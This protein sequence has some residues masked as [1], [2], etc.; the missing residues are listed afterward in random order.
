M[1]PGKPKIY[2]KNGR[3]HTKLFVFSREHF[4]VE[5]VRCADAS[6]WCDERNH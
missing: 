4:A 2:R 1:K 6:R 3:W 5:W